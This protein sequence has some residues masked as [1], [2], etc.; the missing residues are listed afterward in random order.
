MPAAPA[1][2]A[3]C[4]EQKNFSVTIG[5]NISKDVSNFAAKNVVAEN[6][7]LPSTLPLIRSTLV[8]TSL[9]HLRSSADCIIH[10]ARSGSVVLLLTRQRRRSCSATSPKDPSNPSR[11]SLSTAITSQRV[12]YFHE[13]RCLY[14][15]WTW[16][17]SKSRTSVAHQVVV[18]SLHLNRGKPEVLKRW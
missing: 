11:C 6:V 8:P 12:L 2:L 4:R 3:L 10:L 18:G 14:N 17:T 5:S 16:D 1:L 15:Q 13:L 9:S 7:S